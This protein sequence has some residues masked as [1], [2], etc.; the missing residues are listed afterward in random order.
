MYPSFFDELIK[1]AEKDE[2]SLK[3]R[4]IEGAVTARPWVKRGITGAIPAAVAANFLLPMKDSPLKRRLI[5]GAG[6][7]GGG[8]AMGDLALRRWAKKHPRRIAAKELKRQEKHA[9]AIR[10]IAAMATDLRMTGIGGVKRPPFPT[11]DSKQQAFQKFQNAQQPGKFTTH[12]QAKHLR[13]P[14]AAIPQI[15]PLPR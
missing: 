11:E 14:G 4:A 2:R 12:T 10:K 7:L 3:T 13:G 15:A 5:A 9:E 6:I 1:I 8:A